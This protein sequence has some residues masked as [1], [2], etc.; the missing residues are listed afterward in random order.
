[1]TAFRTA[2]D[3]AAA[4]ATSSVADTAETFEFVATGKP[5]IV[6]ASVAN[7]HGSV[8]LALV[9]GDGWAGKT[10][11]IGAAV[12]NK[13]TD[14]YVESGYGVNSDGKIEILATPASGKR[15][16]TDHVLTLRII[17]L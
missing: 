7:T 9:A 4:A 13:V 12:Q 6:E 16:A 1:M 15:L 17:Q 10:T 5:F 3:S 2:V 11:T 8:A 14:F